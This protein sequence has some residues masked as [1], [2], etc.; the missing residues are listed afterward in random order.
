MSFIDIFRLFLYISTLFYSILLLAGCE[1]SSASATASNICRDFIASLDSRGEYAEAERDDCLAELLDLSPSAQQD[2]VEDYLKNDRGYIPSEQIIDL[3]SGLARD[4]RR[5]LMSLHTRELAR[6][7]DETVEQVLEDQLKQ[8][9]QANDDLTLVVLLH[10]QGRVLFADHN[11]GDMRVSYETAL[12]HAVS[13]QMDAYKHHLWAGLGLAEMYLDNSETAFTHF[14]EALLGAEKYANRAVALQVCKNINALLVQKSVFPGEQLQNLI[15]EVEASGEET[16]SHCLAAA[17]LH[18]LS[19]Q[20]ENDAI[21][22]MAPDLLQRLEHSLISGYSP[23]ILHVLGQKSYL[24]GDFSNALNIY[25]DVLKHFEGKEDLQGQY[26]ALNSI[27]NIFSDL[28]ESDRAIEMYERALAT[29]DATGLQ[30]WSTRAVIFVNIAT[31]HAIVD[32]H[33]QALIYYEKTAELA[34]ADP[35]HRLNGYLGYHY[36]KSLHAVGRTEEALTLSRR[37]DSRHFGEAKPARG[38]GGVHMACQPLFGH[39]GY[40]EARA[41]IGPRGRD[42]VL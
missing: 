21:I 29:F 8:A 22:D 7:R 16:L 42:H 4:P 35:D 28:G 11:Y 41:L 24:E 2:V 27:A 34:N 12:Q 6:Q 19:E 20:L 33:D 17:K 10:A 36:G 38:G 13:V 31:A 26:R 23:L 30:S 37:V 14:R 40:S 1:R 3:S 25:E 39:G 5:M 18:R 32:R 15:G 9:H